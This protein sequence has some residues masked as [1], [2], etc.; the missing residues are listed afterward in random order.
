M[1]NIEYK[2]AK[3]KL[4]MKNPDI[5]CGYFNIAKDTDK[6]YSSGRLSIP[7]EIEAKVQTLVEARQLK[8]QK[9]KDRISE[10]FPNDSVD[11]CDHTNDINLHIKELG[12]TVNFKNNGKDH[13]LHDVYSFI[14]P[15]KINHL[16]LYY[17]EKPWVKDR[18][19]TAF[20][21]FYWRSDPSQSIGMQNYHN[22]ITEELL[23]QLVLPKK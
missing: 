23:R 17:P 16:L 5:W 1:N 11:L 7:D 20:D 14:G 4:G 21:W 10:I 12:V 9:L 2:Q 3:E 18:S 8:V 22:V 13:F 19:Q 6:S 15:G